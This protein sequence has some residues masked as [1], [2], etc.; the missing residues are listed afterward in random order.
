MELVGSGH[1]TSVDKGVQSAKLFLQ[2]TTSKEAEDFR[3]IILLD[4]SCGYC[5]IAMN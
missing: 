3:L 4:S 1:E 2:C 5:I